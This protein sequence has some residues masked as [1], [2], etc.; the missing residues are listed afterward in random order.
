MVVR[1]SFLE[2]YYED[3]DEQE[4]CERCD[5]RNADHA[6]AEFCGCGRSLCG[7]AGE[8]FAL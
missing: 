2:G 7:F 1:F 3:H 6:V 5:S 8:A 4:E